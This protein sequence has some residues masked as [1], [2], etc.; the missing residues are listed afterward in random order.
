MSKL[1]HLCKT[2]N[3]LL[4]ADEIQ[5]GFGRSGKM[6]ASEWDNCK[7]DMIVMGK[8][9]SGGLMP[10][11]GVVAMDHVMQHIGPGDHGSTFGGN[12][13][14]MAVAKKAIEVLVEEGMV[15]NS[16]AMGELL[17]GELQHIKSPLVSAVR[18]RGLFI[19]LDINRDSKVDAT[20]FAYCCIK[21]GLLT[22]STHDYTVR[23]TPALVINKDEIHEAVKIIK[24]SVLDLE[25][26]NDS[27]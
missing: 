21:N 26:I 19:G 1:H 2:H 9:M 3:V 11:S 5:S 18:G 16:L 17:K 27:K 10:I 6:M 23:L 22:K 7:P 15:E 4:V 24:Q 12:P 14:A 20:D 8:A 25:K 13:L